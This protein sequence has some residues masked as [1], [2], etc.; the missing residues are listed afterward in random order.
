MK[1]LK[2]ILLN[3]ITFGG[4]YFFAKHKAKKIVHNTNT[5]LTYSTKVNFDIDE[6]IRG[7]GGVDNITASS[8]TLS[9]LKVNIKDNKLI[10]K[11]QLAKLGA[12]G[13]MINN[14]QVVA[15]FG[16]NAIMINQ[17]LIERIK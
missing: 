13:V 7:L 8:A 11:E 16:D 10:S 1:K 14:N 2:W 9:S 4:V 6:L 5:D 17:S 12:K 3:I 15:L